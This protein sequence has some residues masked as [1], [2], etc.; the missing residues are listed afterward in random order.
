[1][2]YLIGISGGSGSGKTSTCHI[3]SE[4][5]ENVTIIS[6]D[7]FYLELKDGENPDD[8]DFD[9]PSRFDWDLIYKTLLN[10]KKEKNIRIPV[11]DFISHK[12]KGSYEFTK[13]NCIIFEGILALYD[14]KIRNLFDVKNICRYTCRY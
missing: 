1:M 2:C 7:S 6:M 5:I 11:Y 4:K 8:I 12:R 14:L 9:H 13:T 10:I 3:I